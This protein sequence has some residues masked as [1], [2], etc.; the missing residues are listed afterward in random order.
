MDTLKEKTAKGL[1]WGMFNNGTTQLLNFVIGIFLLRLLTPSDYGIVGVLSIFT[2]I[3]G[4]LQSSGFSQA[5]TNM[6]RPEARD[7][8]A[9]FW[10]NVLVSIA[11]YAV[12]FFCAPLIAAYFR[13]PVLVGVSRFVFLAFVISSFGIAHSAYMFKNLMVKEIAIIGCVALIVSGAVGV[14]LAFSGKAYWSLAWQQVIYIAV[15][16]L[17]R[18][19][20]TPW[21]PS[22]HV[23]FSPIKR[24]FGF[25]VKILITSIINTL[26]ANI[27]TFIFGR[28]FPMKTVGVFTQANKWNTMAN[29]FI[30]GTVAQVA[31]PVLAQIS[32]DE[33]R[34][35]RV[36]RKMMRFTAFLSFPAMFGLAMVAD[37][38]VML[39]ITAKWTACVPLLQLLCI[40]G[41][42]L[43]FHTLYQNLA[44]SKGRSDIYLWCNIL[45]I[46]MQIGLVVFFAR[47]GITVM[48]AACSA[49][50]IAFLFVWQV[51]ASRF[52]GI[53]FKD[54]IMDMLP[55]LVVAAAVMCL[56]YFITMPVKHN[57]VLFLVR[58]LVAAVLYFA[59]MKLLRVKILDECIDYI[60]KRKKK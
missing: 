30:S 53:M 48:V 23:D 52:A 1:V 20:F 44:I 28:L 43:P 5:L 16:N 41:A 47:Y 50:N 37:E 40:G 29:S 19:Y 34:E 21:R 14:A 8:N 9:V 11:I 12:L 3:A 2:A 60:L 58:I 46:A 39:T 55:F 7:Y 51:F 59:A 36:F 4:N 31:Q 24:M 6:K 10:F 32:D 17:G 56:T 22:L 35:R 33:E 49:L 27:L 54:I 42:F 13:Q 38:F 18:Y 45:L 15:V 25:S 26:S 57:L